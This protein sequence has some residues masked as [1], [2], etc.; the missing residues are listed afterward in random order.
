[1]S[2]LSSLLG[3]AIKVPIVI[4]VFVG[5]SAVGQR[6]FVIFCGEESR[7]RLWALYYCME[8]I[9]NDKSYPTAAGHELFF[10]LLTCL[11]ADKGSVVV[12]P[13]CRHCS[14]THDP[15]VGFMEL[16]GCAALMRA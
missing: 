15:I 11:A 1:M 12:N 5:C 3:P 9:C 10:H 16:V 13:A 4:K 7:D 6:E 14:F 8:A 2:F